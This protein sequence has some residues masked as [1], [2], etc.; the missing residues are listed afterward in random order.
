MSTPVLLRKLGNLFSCVL[1]SQHEAMDTSVRRF[2]ITTSYICKHT[3]GVLT[4]H[5]NLFG[6]VMISYE[7]KTRAKQMRRV[8]EPEIMCCKSELSLHVA[9]TPPA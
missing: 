7:S 9:A 3:W 2:N 8:S 6:H 1:V 4:I 5:V